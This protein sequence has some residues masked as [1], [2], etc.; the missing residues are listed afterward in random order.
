MTEDQ[1]NTLSDL[2]YTLANEQ[3]YRDNWL[4]KNTAFEL[5]RVIDEAIDLIGELKREGKSNES[6]KAIK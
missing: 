6:G 5:F 1:E 2:N 3:W 4:K